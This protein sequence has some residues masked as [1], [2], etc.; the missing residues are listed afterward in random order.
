[1]RN[2]QPRWTRGFIWMKTLDFLALHLPSSVKLETKQSFIC[3]SLSPSSLLPPSPDCMILIFFFCKKVSYL[4][5]WSSLPSAHS[6]SL[7]HT[8]SWL[9]EVRKYKSH[10]T[11][12]LISIVDIY[13]YQGMK[14][15]SHR[16]WGVSLS[17]ALYY[18]T[19]TSTSHPLNWD[20]QLHYFTRLHWKPG[21]EDWLVTILEY[22]YDPAWWGSW[23][24]HNIWRELEQH[25]P[26]YL[27]DIW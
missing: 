3:F 23:V 1:M 13:L 18:T 26:P 17:C 7:S 4:D 6:Q 19:S 2:I 27:T 8:F 15:Y 11:I 14:R 20:L 21:W 5:C 16:Q 10:R 22:F 25:S 24:K 9:E 12:Y